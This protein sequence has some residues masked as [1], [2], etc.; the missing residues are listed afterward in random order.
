MLGNW[1][2]AV[3]LPPNAEL[4]PTCAPAQPEQLANGATIV[5]YYVPATSEFRPG[6]I[7]NIYVLWRSTLNEDHTVYQ[8]FVELVDGQGERIAQLDSPT[9]H[10]DLWY[11]D[12]MLISKVPLT[13]PARL[14][15]G[16]NFAVRVGMYRLPYTGPVA[17]LKDGKSADETWVTIPF[18]SAGVA[19]VF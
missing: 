9:L 10:T 3:E 18:C 6:K 15:D 13:I 17:V 14:P 7:W 4:T 11:A 16:D 5:G 12:E 2:R 8:M 1:L 19:P